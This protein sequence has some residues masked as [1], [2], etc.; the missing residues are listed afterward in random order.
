MY[1][2]MYSY[3]YINT[4]LVCR[5]FF[6]GCASHCLTKMLFFSGQFSNFEK[7]KKKKK[8]KKKKKKEKRILQLASDNVFG[9]FINR[10]FLFFLSFFFLS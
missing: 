9:Q 3:I 2:Y 7:K 6:I 5:T 10:R 4:G 1:S 8:I